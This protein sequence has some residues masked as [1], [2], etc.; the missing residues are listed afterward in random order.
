MSVKQ[1]SVFLENKPGALY[2]MTGVLAQHKV[3]MRAFSLA[4]TSDFGI[5]RMIVSD[6]Y[7]ATTILR[8]AG[9]VHSISEVLAVSVPDVPGGLNKIL[10][11]L[12]DAGVNV[13]YMYALSNKDNEASIICK[14]SNG[15]KAA[16]LLKS[17][18][19]ELY[20]QEDIMRIFC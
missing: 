15:D 7:A 4:E 2:A 5:A 11:V 6:I 20:S 13:E 16:E 12:T 1:I 3:D 10:H 9:Y 19:I 8:E 18:D 17:K 14:I